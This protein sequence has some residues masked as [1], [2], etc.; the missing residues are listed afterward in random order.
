MKK[1]ATG[2]QV[3]LRD[4]ATPPAVLAISGLTVL[5]LL[6]LVGLCVFAAVRLIRK[7]AKAKS[8][9]Q[10]PAPMPTLTGTAQ[11]GEAKEDPPAGK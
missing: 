11:E 4:I 3:I 6:L 8:A 10:A 5:L 9:A 1:R 7:A 2:K